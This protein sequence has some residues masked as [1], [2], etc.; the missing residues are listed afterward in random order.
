M[1]TDDLAAFNAAS[2]YCEDNTVRHLVIPAGVYNL[3]DYWVA[4]HILTYENVTVEAFG[5]RVNET[6]LWVVAQY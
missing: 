1:A 4:P 2:D 6:L 5:A 3:S